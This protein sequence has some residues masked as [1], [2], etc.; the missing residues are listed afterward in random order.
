M[1]AR[2]LFTRLVPFVVFASLALRAPVFARPT[3][4]APPSDPP[5]TVAEDVVYG[6][7]DGLA[8]TLDVITPKKP[9]GAGVIVFVSAEYRSNR[10]LL[11]RFRP[12]MMP[13]VDRG[14]V[15]FAVMHAS[16]PKYTVPEI[17]EDAH[18]AVRFVK[19][20]AKKYG[21]DPVRLGA[22]GGSAGGH[23]ALMAGCAGRPGDPVAKDPVERESSGVGAVACLFPP[24]DFPALE[25]A[26]TP[27]VAAAFDFREFNR[28]TGKYERVT[29][30]R[31]RQIARDL[32]PITHAAKGSAPTF[33]VHGD[34]DEIVPIAQSEALVA[35]LKGCGVTCELKVVRGK[36]HYGLWIFKEIPFLVEWFDK[37][38]PAKK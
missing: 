11:A 26:C 15:V 32:S 16:Q 33:I 10:D 7:R 30:A 17:V 38:L 34:L 21:V 9:N 4:P 24:T 29:V 27:D 14:Y 13:F 28:A 18:R 25:G 37:H 1:S 6:S 19:H 3:Q 31:G 23:L 22:A 35:K 5:F 20:H 36:H 12:A 2:A 8:L